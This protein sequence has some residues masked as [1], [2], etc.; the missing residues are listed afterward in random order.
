MS[1][2]YICILI[3]LTTDFHCIL[4]S[5]AHTPSNSPAF[6]FTTNTLSSISTW[7]MCMGLRLVLG[8]DQLT[9]SHKLEENGLSILS[10]QQSAL[11]PLL[12]AEPCVT[13]PPSHWKL[14]GFICAD[15]VHCYDWMTLLYS[16]PP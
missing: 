6:V 11:A 15:L 12:R 3:I 16:F 5:S 13:L 10:R 7:H 8:Q 9:R 14:I 1:N 4:E 2:L